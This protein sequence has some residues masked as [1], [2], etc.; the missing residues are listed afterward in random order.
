MNDTLKSI[1]AFLE[2]GRPE[3]QVAAAQILGEL[4][5]KDTAVVKALAGSLRRSPVLARFCL[6]A[7]SK[8]QTD[9]A[10]ATVARAAIDM[11]ALGDHALHLVAELG[12]ATHPI[13]AQAYPQASLEQRARILGMLGKHIG[14]DA[15]AV[16]IPALLTPESTDLAQRLLI[17]AQPQ[18]APP[19]QKALRDGL[20]KHLGE[21]LP[22]ACL[23]NV[24][25]VLAA[26]DAEGSRAY[27]LGL[28]GPETAPVVRSSALRALQGSKLSATQ[29]RMLLDLLED[30]Q[31]KGVHDAVREVLAK[32]PELPE[33][34]LPVCKRLLL[35][36]QPEQRLFALRMLRTAGGLDLAK[37][38]IKL[39]DHDDERFRHAAAELLA[40]NRQAF[41]L[42]LRLLL[43]TRAPGLAESCA[44]ILGKHAPQLAPKTVRAVAEKAV[45]LLGVN[46]RIADLLLDVV[47]AAGVQKLAPFLVERCIRLRRTSRHTD[48]MHVLARTVAVLPTDDEVRYQL[49]LTKLMHD[50]TQPAV[51]NAAPGNPTM[52]FLA[53]LIR[54]GFPLFDRLRKESAM[55]P[56]LMLRIATHFAAAVG[57]ERKL[58]TELLQF[59]ATRTKGRAGDEARLVLRAVG[60]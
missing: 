54:N 7:L 32:L 6:D 53:V 30:V 12:S 27:L 35:A 21:A 47:L 20:Q 11:D 1:T 14:K 28:I 17:A 3:L 19:L 40:N 55:T 37:V 10:I 43:T 24:V 59:L 41:D 49:A 56:E 39:L 16:F 44:V 23:A 26:V 36:R 2:T 51:E 13:L 22:E 33:A 60:G 48:A 29:V 38:A 42:L 57:A 25:T 45:K 58:A 18:F 52:G 50:A 34:M 9:E 46:A 31:Q 8:I 15:L 4:R 5:L